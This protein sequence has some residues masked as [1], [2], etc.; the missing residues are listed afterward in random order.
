M[1]VTGSILCIENA[2][3]LSDPNGVFHDATLYLH[4]NSNDYTLAQ[5]NSLR[6]NGL[7]PFS[8]Y[9]PDPNRPALKL[10]PESESIEFGPEV[11]AQETRIQFRTKEELLEFSTVELDDHG[12][13]VIVT[14][15]GW[16]Q[17][18]LKAKK[19]GKGTVKAKTWLN[20]QIANTY[21]IQDPKFKQLAQ[22]IQCY[23]FDSAAGEVY[24]FDPSAATNPPTD[25]VDSISPQ[26]IADTSLGKFQAHSP[27]FLFM[28]LR[29]DELRAICA[30]LFD[31]RISFRKNIMLQS[32]C[33]KWILCDSIKI[34]QEFYAAIGKVLARFRIA[35][36]VK[37]DFRLASFPVLYMTKGQKG[38]PCSNITFKLVIP[39]QQNIN[40][41]LFFLA[42]PQLRGQEDHALV[43]TSSHLLYPKNCV[44]HINGSKTPL[45]YTNKQGE[46][47][48]LCILWRCKLGD[49]NTFRLDFEL[50][51]ENYKFG[52][53]AQVVGH[54]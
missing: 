29:S 37:Q 2:N 4:E 9:D 45:F 30:I 27:L 48:P 46:L 35:C 5:R 33:E 12:A 28:N 14:T 22:I 38:P 25:S 18:R 36:N 40:A 3:K 6:D 53:V 44:L 16:E 24:V 52:L 54:W 20:Q 11:F 47:T 41:E 17:S 51:L 8:E 7:I 26:A 15:H 43:E 50:D 13:K 19:S 1:E 49:W 34:R 21:G 32:L 42:A 23:V 39:K 31:Q 10:F